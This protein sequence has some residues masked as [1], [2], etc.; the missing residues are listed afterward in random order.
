M[1]D[2]AWELLSANFSDTHAHTQAEESSHPVKAD[3][4]REGRET[5]WQHVNRDYNLWNHKVQLV[6]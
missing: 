3:Q 5:K 4:R 6:T 1:L 2:G